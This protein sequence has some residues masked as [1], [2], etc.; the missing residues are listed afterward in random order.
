V[1]RHVP[2]ISSGAI[3]RLFA[4]V[5]TLGVVVADVA[6]EAGLDPAIAEDPDAR[7][8]IATL[9]ALWEAVLRRVPRDDLAL[10]GAERYEPSDYGLV[11]FVAMNSA[12]LGEM[13]SHVV[14]FLGLWTD[15]PAMRLH[16]GGELRVEYRTALADRPGL[17]C[18]NEAALAEVLHGARL[19]TQTAFAPREVHLAHPA[20][21]D[22]TAH[23]AF[24]RCPV[25]FARP[26]TQLVLRPADLVLPLPKADPQLG[27]FLRK[28][29]GEALDRRSG[30]GDSPIDVLRSLIAEALQTGV[31]A[32]DQLARKMGTTERTLRRRLE[33]SGTSFRGLLDETRAE[34][35]RRYIR[36]Q[37]LPQAEVAFLLGFTDTSAFHRAFKRWT[38]MTP[39]AWRNRESVVR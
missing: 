14:R 20:P 13:L 18:A 32:L 10:V 8:P 1:A 37:H 23:E 34:L 24:F 19:G 29:A 11:G 21:R 17:R 2:A 35:A 5:A 16:E 6:A 28:M 22:V 33:E 15:D 4:T 38:G 27:A 39:G 31:P 9:H 12:T 3:R 7:V 30:P 25:H 26:H 36:D